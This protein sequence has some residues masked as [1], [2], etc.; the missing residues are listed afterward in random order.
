V[1]RSGSIRSSKENEGAAAA[2]EADDEED[3][4]CKDGEDDGVAEAG[5]EG[6]AGPSLIF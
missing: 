5:G 6:D 4:G 1:P 2:A 3:E